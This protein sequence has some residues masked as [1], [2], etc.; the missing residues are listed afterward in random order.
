M[1]GGGARARNG[2]DR[3][4]RAEK[5]GEQAGL[6]Q[7]ALPAVAVEDLPDLHDREVERPQDEHD[8]GVGHA[9]Q[10]RQRQRDAHAGNDGDRAIGRVDPEAVWAA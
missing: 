7:L 5:D 2:A 8:R 3:A 10:H 9:E 4:E 1:M 6:A